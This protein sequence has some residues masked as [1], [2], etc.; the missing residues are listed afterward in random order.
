[1]LPPT[2][3]CLLRTCATHAWLLGPP[4][5]RPSPDGHSRFRP[6]PDGPP[7]AFR[8]T[9]RTL[10][11]Y[12]LFCISLGF[13]L[14]LLSTLGPPLALP[15]VVGPPLA[16]LRLRIHP[17]ALGFLLQLRSLVLCGSL[18]GPR[19]V[20]PRPLR[21]L[22]VQRSA[23]LTFLIVFPP[24]FLSLDARMYF[25]AAALHH[26]S[27]P[28]SAVLPSEGERGAVAVALLPGRPRFCPSW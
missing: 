25:R 2:R 24:G 26:R 1:M 17:L 19:P 5:F 8:P 14:A 4:R 23:L 27:P 15:M 3:L 10:S 20:A 16:L 7:L 6:S 13:R 9:Y 11:N 18:R 28:L 12:L 21:S 22:K